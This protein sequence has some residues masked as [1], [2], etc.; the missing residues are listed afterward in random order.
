MRKSIFVK[1]FGGHFLVIILLVMLILLF[2]FHE[3]KRFY[4]ANLEKELS[5]TGEALKYQVLFYLEENRIEELQDFMEKFGKKIET[6]LTLINRE[7]RVLADSEKNPEM[8]ENHKDRPE[9]F[10]AY[11]GQIGRSLRF[12]RTLKTDMLYIGLPIIKDG[13][14]SHVI[15]LSLYLHDI[16]H[17]I[18]ILRGKITQIALAI[19]LCVFLFSFFLSRSFSKPVKELREA[20]QKIAAG[21]FKVRVFT[22][23]KGEFSD[24]AESFNIMTEKIQSLFL[25]TSRKKEE[26]EG[27]LSSIEEGLFALDEN[28]RILF[29][30]DSF[31][32][33][34]GQ[35]DINGKFYW[36][37]LREANFRE[38]VESFRKEGKNISEELDLNERVFLCNLASLH[39][40]KEIVV[41]L[42]DISEF[43]TL[44]KIKRD[45][46]IN[47]S[48]ELRTPLTA[49][50][51]FIETLEEEIDEKNEHYLNIIKRNTDRLINIVKDLMQL[52][53]L[54][55]KGTDL[56]IETVD[57][58]KLLENIM[59][60]FEERIKAKSLEFEII[61]EKDFSPVQADLFK[62]EQMFINIVDNAV[63]YSED[64]K[65]II[66]LKQENDQ[67]V[68]QVSDTGIGIAEE[69]Q[70]RI[71]ERFYMTDKSRSRKLGGTGLGLSIVKHIVKLHKG[72]I[73]VE[74]RLGQGTTFTI[75]LPFQQ[76]L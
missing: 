69:H 4:I 26:L 75:K 70:P 57:L 7:G 61:A 46:I 28:N 54:E 2:S 33:I 62:I 3:I 58:E 42:H 56:E 34:S 1:V 40:G 9:I 36:E 52:S 16:K 15:R 49:I 55:E 31:K 50:K 29:A 14:V 39:R 13:R 32:K 10:R 71:F 11:S 21:D 30:N 43:K 51:G 53:E 38:M 37:I 17:L 74:S 22:R 65:I 66:T 24:L 12:S 6:R 64:G 67:A 44:E 23:K 18:A 48:H 35:D 63:K 59:K 25:E 68:V 5:H 8:M 60:I 20:S 76:K 45:L 41:T 47:A 19:L 27:I 73:S 72:D